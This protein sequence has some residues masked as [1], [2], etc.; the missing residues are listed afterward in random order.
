MNIKKLLQSKVAR[1]ASWLMV[2]KIIQ[3]VLS[4]VVGLMVARYLGP[5]SYGL[6]NYAGGY[7]TFFA[8]LCN[9]G[10]NSIL[11]KEFID[12]PDLQGETIG[13]TLVLRLISSG[14]SILIIFGV[15]LS[16]DSGEP[17]TVLVVFLSSL[18]VIFQIFETFNYWFQSRLESRATAVAT[19]LAYLVTVVYRVVLLVLHA[20]VVWFALAS[21]LDYGVLAVLLVVLYRRH[22][23][24][25]LHWSFKRSQ[26]LLGKSYHFILP[27][28]MVSIYGFCDKFMLKQMMD[29]S[30]VG[31]YSAAQV[32][33]NMWCFVLSALIDS[34]YPPIMEAH[35]AGNSEGYL[36]LNRKLYCIVFYVSVS[37]SSL[38]SAFSGPIVGLLY[39]A[40]YSGAVVPLSI[41]T[42]YTAFS[43]LGVARNAWIVSENKQSYLKWMYILSAL[44]NVLFNLAL[45]PPLGATGAA[46]ASLLTEIATT[47]VIPTFF[48]EIRPNVR[49][50]LDA[51]TFKDL[52]EREC[53]Q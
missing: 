46:I 17:T 9:L 3:M 19:L 10:I 39:G 18:S 40:D 21:A 49:L 53:T 32:I 33:C 7:V 48:R 4:L 30:E 13:S 25:S 51:I 41:I 52:R 24:A 22:G 43:Y 42:W 1:N 35:K 11:V 28:L 38:I 27:S 14:L 45:I 47:F 12:Y 16:A 2:G 15:S 36:R 37:A 34:F 5:G 29:S 20:D 31:C 23:G 6:L 8:S 26:A 44:L 50:M